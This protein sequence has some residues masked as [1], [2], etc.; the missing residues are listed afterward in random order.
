MSTV[1]TREELVRAMSEGA[2]TVLEALPPAHYAARALRRRAP[3][4]GDQ[5][6]R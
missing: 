5:R 2:A 1:I 4:R 6:P 3:A